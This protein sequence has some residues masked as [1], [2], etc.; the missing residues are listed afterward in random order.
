MDYAEILYGVDKAVATITLNRPERLN[1]WTP[2]MAG[3]FRRA[4]VEARD[5]PAVRAIVV[6][7]AGKGFCAGVDMGALGGMSA[8]GKTEAKPFASVDESARADFQHPMTWLPA[9]DKPVIAAINGAAAGLGF[10]ISLFCDLRFASKKSA[11]V[12]SFSKRGLIAEHGTSWM[13]TRL[14]GHSRALDLMFSSRRVSGEEAYRIGLADRL[15]APERLLDE[16]MEYARDLAMNVSPRST[17]IIKR[18][19]WDALFVELAESMTDADREMQI[20]LQ[21]ADFREGVAHFIEKRPAK[22]T[23]E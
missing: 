3:D 23:G 21:S 11:F 14:V 15:C 6:T 22:F 18:Q 5:D 17:R 16:A 4:M 8:A 9:I 13:L 12:T 20:S 19:L 2:V 10:A 7:G 1:A